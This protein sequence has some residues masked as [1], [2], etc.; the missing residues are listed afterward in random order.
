MRAISTRKVSFQCLY[1]VIPVRD[2]GIQLF[3]NHQNVVFLH[4]MA[5]FMLTNL[6]KFLDPSVKHWDLM[7]QNHNVRTVVDS[8]AVSLSI[9]PANK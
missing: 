8:F 7:G 6:I 4:K 2:T 5:T 1:D 3:H 9:D